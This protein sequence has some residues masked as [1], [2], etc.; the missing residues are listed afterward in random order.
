[1][2]TAVNPITR[3]SLQT[4]WIASREGLPLPA[5]DVVVVSLKAMIIS[6]NA[7]PITKPRFLARAKK[8]EARPIFSLGK[9]PM[10]A[11]LFAGLK[12]PI[13]MPKTICLHTMSNS[14]APVF[15]KVN[16]KTVREVRVRPIVAGILT[17]TRSENFP[18]KG[19]ITITVRLTGKISMPTL[20]G[21]NSKIF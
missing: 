8:L 19:A 14:L 2:R 1:M 5:F 12:S 11:L 16:E 20:D 6:A 21:E 7:T 15:R 4:S 13:P 9:E 17:P 3:T 18:P 10:I